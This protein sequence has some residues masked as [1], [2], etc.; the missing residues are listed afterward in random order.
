MK[1]PWR[2][3]FWLILLSS[4]FH[5]TWE[6][7]QSPLY[8]CSVDMEA[9]FWLCLRATF[10]DVG[11]MLVLYTIHQKVHSISK[12]ALIGAALAMVIEKISIEMER[13]AYFDT[14]PLIP[15]IEVGLTPVLQMAL[16]PPLVFYILRK[17][18][19]TS[20]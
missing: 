13:W 10:G 7:A 11:I 17:N 14:M 19:S 18:F 5:L 15:G 16:I 8:T 12:M 1:V 9:C 20:V 4:V 2:N 3:L 6:L